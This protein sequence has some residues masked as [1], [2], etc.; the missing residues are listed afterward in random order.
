MLMAMEICSYRASNLESEESDKE[1]RSFLQLPSQVGHVIFSNLPAVPVASS[2]TRRNLEKCLKRSSQPPSPA[3]IAQLTPA[4][5]RYGV[6]LSR[7]SNNASDYTPEALDRE[8]GPLECPRPGPLLATVLG[9][10]TTAH[11]A[12]PRRP[13]REVVARW[14][15]GDFSP[16][17]RLHRP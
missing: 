1:G 13:S 16:R 3:L 6:A 12:S 17:R 14:R 15:R 5:S 9:D 2:I 8:C 10:A 11:D 4:S 7:L